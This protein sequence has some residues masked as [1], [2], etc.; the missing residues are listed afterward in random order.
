[1]AC[2]NL[3]AVIECWAKPLVLGT[4]VCLTAPL[5]LLPRLGR[6]DWA[7]YFLAHRATIVR[8]DVNIGG[9]CVIDIVEFGPRT[10]WPLGFG[11]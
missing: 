6:D 3:G 4:T 8:E 5:A 2:A 9:N 10:P 1:M 11:F 7:Y